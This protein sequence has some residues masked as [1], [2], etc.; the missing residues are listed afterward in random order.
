MDVF[1]RSSVQ[2][3]LFEILYCTSAETSV[4]GVNSALLYIL[5]L[6]EEFLHCVTR[7]RKAFL[8]FH[9]PWLLMSSYIT[10]TVTFLFKQGCSCTPSQ[11]STQLHLTLGA[12]R[13]QRLQIIDCWSVS[14]SFP[15][16]L[17]AYGNHTCEDT[18]YVYF[19]DVDVVNPD[20]KSIMTYVA[21]FLQYSKKAPGSGDEAQVCLSL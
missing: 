19:A 21:Q 10:C 17:K 16:L 1:N 4:S 9:P 6:L 3:I 18:Y 5:T 15:I 13:V 2:H 12:G 7:K 8:P 11:D 20:E 14:S